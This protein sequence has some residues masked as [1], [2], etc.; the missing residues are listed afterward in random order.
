MRS[1]LQSSEDTLSGRLVPRH[2]KNRAR[3][4]I[5]KHGIQEACNG[6]LVIIR[7]KPWVNGQLCVAAGSDTKGSRRRESVREVDFDLEDARR[8]TNTLT[9]L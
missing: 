3:V 2:G 7:G 1:G 5:T 9:M 8:A 4:Y 6:L